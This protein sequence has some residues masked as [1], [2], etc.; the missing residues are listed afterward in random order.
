MSNPDS[1]PAASQNYK[2]RRIVLKLSGEALRESGSMDNISFEILRKI[3]EQIKEVHELGVELAVVI[4]GGNFWR[5]LGAAGR[6]MERTTADYIGMLATV[7]NGLA[8]QT[9]LQSIGVPTRVLTAI[10]MKNVAETFTRNEALRHL[11]V[12][13]VVIFV[14]GIGSPFFSTDTTAALRAN[15]VAA[16]VVFKATKVDGVYDSDPKKNPDAKRFRTLK[17]EDA[18]SRQL[19]IM[20]STAFGLCQD[21]KLPIIVFDML[22][23]S[24]I[25]KAVQ[26]EDVGTLVTADDHLTTEFA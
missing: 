10:E 14:A 8:L 16:D 3:G 4:G 21:N 7:M 25:K 20:D 9:V 5:G 13:R 24:N 17:Y 15:E 12:G 19:K 23:E 2:Y 11:S 22:K 18:L 1:G 6:G 26:G